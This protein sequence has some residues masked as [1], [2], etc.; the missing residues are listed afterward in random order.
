MREEDQRVAPLP[1]V[2]AQLVVSLE[3]LQHAALYVGGI[4]EQHVYGEQAALVH[5]AQR[6]QPA[7]RRLACLVSGLEYGLWFG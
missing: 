1:R 5:V 3:S 6:A 2:V 4:G 7:A